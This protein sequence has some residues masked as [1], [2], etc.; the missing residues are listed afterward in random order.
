MEK[1]DE[2]FRSIQIP[3]DIYVERV[4]IEMK[5]DSPTEYQESVNQRGCLNKPFYN[6]NSIL[7]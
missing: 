3:E 6:L 5:I 2:D 7:I 1:G 4:V